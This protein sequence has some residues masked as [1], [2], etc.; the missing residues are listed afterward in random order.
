[1][2]SE[3]RKK[4]SSSSFFP[5]KKTRSRKPWGKYLVLFACCAREI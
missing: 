5:K 1:M 4:F 3:G 2:K